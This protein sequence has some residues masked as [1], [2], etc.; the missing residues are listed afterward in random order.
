VPFSSIVHTSP[1]ATPLPVAVARYVVAD[2]LS[3]LM[4]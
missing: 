2:A 1:A 3:I 4:S